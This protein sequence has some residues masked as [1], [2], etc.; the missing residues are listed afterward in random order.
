MYITDVEDSLIMHKDEFL[1]YHAPTFLE[2]DVSI[3]N[4]FN[5]NV[6][7]EKGSTLKKDSIFQMNSYDVLSKEYE[8]YLSL[9]SPVQIEGK[10][11]TYTI[12]ID[13]VETEDLLMNFFLLFFLV[14][15]ILIVGLFFIT[16]LFS[17][18]I[19]SPFYLILKQIEQFE[20]D[21]VNVFQLPTSTI[22]EF[23]RLGQSIEKLIH[24]NTSIYASQREFIDNAAH[25]LQTPLAVFK[26]KVDGLVQDSNITENQARALNVLNDTI[27]RMERLNKN[28]LLL[29]KI[30]NDA[31]HSTGEVN[32]NDILIKNMEFFT[33]QAASKQLT[34]QFSSKEK[35]KRKVNIDLIEI[36]LSNLLMNAI[37]HN[38][39]N[40]KINIITTSNSIEILNSGTEKLNSEAL[41]K[42]FSKDNPSKH[43]TGL[44][45]S[46]VK[47]IVDLNNWDI[48]Y[49]FIDKQHSFKIVLF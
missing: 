15:I 28:L 49:A 30:D 17:K 19:W 39:K 21:K 18:K 29:S 36:F 20:I 2:E 32:I 14:F 37:R 6:K 31:Y 1:K 13:L 16:R 41:F 10:R 48:Q 46:I 38:I 35:L 45:L 23:D 42:R 34:I 27:V 25:E 9:Y 22:H 40:G 4:K 26:A 43:G 47:K 24:K 33:E 7:L 11:Y 44:G 8:P 5:R 12:K 3:W